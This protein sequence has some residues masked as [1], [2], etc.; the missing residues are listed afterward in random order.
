MVIFQEFDKSIE[1]ALLG[2]DLG[3]DALGN[4]IKKWEVTSGVL[5]RGSLSGL[6]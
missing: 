4:S 1:E 3:K 6:G 5:L 2:I